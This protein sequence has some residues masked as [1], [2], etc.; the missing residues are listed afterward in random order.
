VPVVRR[1]VHSERCWH[2]DYLLAHL[3]RYRK[4]RTGLAPRCVEA[5]TRR[6]AIQSAFRI[7]SRVETIRTPV[8]VRAAAFHAFELSTTP[9]GPAANSAG[10]ALNWRRRCDVRGCRRAQRPPQYGQHAA[11]DILQDRDC[12]ALRLAT[13]TSGGIGN[14]TTESAGRPIG[15]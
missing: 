7:A 10:P 15:A 9:R 5:V 8:R 1:H 14:L 11:G 13:D 12:P 6:S 2:R 4:S 3:A